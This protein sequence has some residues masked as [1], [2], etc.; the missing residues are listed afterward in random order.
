MS[1]CEKQEKKIIWKYVNLK[2]EFGGG[3]KKERVEKMSSD[4]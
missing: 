3:K 2:C 1:K 4:S